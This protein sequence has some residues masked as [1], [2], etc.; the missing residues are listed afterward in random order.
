MLPKL[1]FALSFFLLIITFPFF[2]SSYP[3]NLSKEAFISIINVNYNSHL[4]SPFS[5]SALRINDKN[6]G[7]DEIIDFSYF[8]DFENPV[9]PLKFYFFS[10][11]ANIISTSFLDFAEYEEKVNK[12]Q[13]SEIIL[14]L[15]HSEISYIFDFLKNLHGNLPNYRYNFDLQSNNSYSHISSILND[16]DNYIGNKNP[17]RS[18]YSY[19]RDL[20]LSWKKSDK[21]N[22]LEVFS[23]NKNE[24][25]KTYSLK[26]EP[27]FALHSI[28]LFLVLSLIV[29]I[30]SIYQT[31]VIKKLIFYSLSAV[32]IIQC[33]DFLILFISGIIGTTIL[34]QDY[35]STQNIFRN[36][37]R[38]S[39]FFP[40]H[41]AMAF[42][43][44]F[45]FFSKKFLRFY[46]ILTSIL[47]I[48][49]IFSEFFITREFPVGDLFISL[50]I[51]IM[52][53][54]FAIQ[55]FF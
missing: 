54:L 36:D 31:L 9:F 29:F 46:W 35:F 32:K 6:S 23:S 16:C 2:S 27:N 44:Y 40:F 24:I 14:N 13:L 1:N 33:I 8:K 4:K 22:F 48:V 43:V 21:Q 11:Q 7:F 15:S 47:T 42:N 18:F 38:F 50:P 28:I 52:T 25:N 45:S 34:L 30:F 5:K 51:F 53:S 19:S 12:A 55:S 3:E 41:I 20:S 37:F 17:G 26:N 39:F 10:E 49:Y